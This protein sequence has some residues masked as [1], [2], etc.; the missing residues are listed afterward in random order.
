MYDEFL[1]R[2]KARLI[3]SENVDQVAYEILQFV[4][5]ISQYL[6]G[7]DDYR[8]LQLILVFKILFR[9]FVIRDWFNSNIICNKYQNQNIVI[10]Q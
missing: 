3:E 9:S 8:T 5:D 4:D 1:F 6:K 10:A 2:L 7:G